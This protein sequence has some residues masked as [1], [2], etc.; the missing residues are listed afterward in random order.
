MI[1]YTKNKILAENN[2]WITK[3]IAIDEL[4][5]AVKWKPRFIAKVRIARML[6]DK[7]KIEKNQ[8]LIIASSMKPDFE[9]FYNL[10]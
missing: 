6:M 2:E 10:N 9:T 3:S 1:T 5:W 8:A 4:L 7:L